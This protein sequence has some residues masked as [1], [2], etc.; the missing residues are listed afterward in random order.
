MADYPFDRTFVPTDI[1]RNVMKTEPHPFFI[2]DRSG[3]KNSVR[4][5]HQA[6][7]W[8][9]GYQNYFPLRENTNPSVLRIL[10]EL[11]TGVSVCNLTELHMARK[12]GFRGEQIL[13]EPTRRDHEA[14]RLAEEL[15]AAWLINSP[16]LLPD[17]IPNRLILRY[18]PDVQNI[19]RIHSTKHDQ[20]KNG[21]SARQL[22][23]AV[24]QCGL[25]SIGL[26]LQ[27][28]EYAVQSGFWAK[29]TATLL[30]QAAD[31]QRETSVQIHCC[32]IGEGPGLIY[33]ASMEK[34]NLMEEI[35]Q[36]REVY[37]TM[38][39][40]DLRPVLLGGLTKQLM[41]PHGILV[42]EVLELRKGYR[43]F[44]VVDAG[45]CQFLRASLKQAYRHISVLGKREMTG[46]KVYTIVGELPNR[47][48][49]LDNKGRTLPPLEV[50]DHLIIHDMG[51]GTRSMAVLYGSHPVS[52][53]YLYEPDGSIRLIGKGRSAEEVAA[54]LTAW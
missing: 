32:M 8:M 31:L 36:V 49:R 46:R 34:L 37:E 14:Q 24:K 5:L 52:A 6:F 20:D 42:T 9:P 15:D 41:D 19:T 43:S 38:T 17:P 23:D 13:Y 25:R 50:G 45:I 51:S 2:Y 48:D 28:S 7:E 27:M 35:R 4:S 12:C 10:A 3:L 26:A 30:K 29:K 44:A 21:F 40:E 11:G 39:H 47:F 1:I 53:E 54:F 22:L 16:W 18:H 33:R